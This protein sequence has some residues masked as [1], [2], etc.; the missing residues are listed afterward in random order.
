[1]KDFSE[2]VGQLGKRVERRGEEWDSWFHGTLGIIGPFI[3]SI[4]ALIVIALVIGVVSFVN[5]AAQSQLLTQ[6]NSFLLNNLYLFF[7][8]FLFFSYTSYLSKLTPRK[9]FYISPVFTAISAVIGFWLFAK[10]MAVANF[11]SSILIISA[12]ISWIDTSYYQIFSF[13]LLLGYLILLLRTVS[14]RPGR[15]P[16]ETFR[17]RIIMREEKGMHRLY[18]S[19]KDRILGGVC[20]GIAEYLG[21]DP[22]IIRL[23]WVVGSLAWGTGI[24]AYIIAWII[25][26]RNPKDAWK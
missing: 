19:G 11:Y 1:V 14:Q 20:G 16:R 26:P 2:E 23:L 9:Y 8:I 7:L 18:R 15:I 24:L 6:I 22:V 21:V 4:F 12:F 10:V 17:Q 25:I 3:S 13:V 5:P